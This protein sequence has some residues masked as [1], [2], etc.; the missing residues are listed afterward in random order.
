M[1]ILKAI[2]LM[3]GCFCGFFG[4]FGGISLFFRVY[5]V[6]NTNGRGVFE[7]QKKELILYCLLLA[8]GVTAWVIR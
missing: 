1:V 7:K 6:D 3:V 4:I 2:W 8:V 5:S